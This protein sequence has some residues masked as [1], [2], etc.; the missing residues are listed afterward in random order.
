MDLSDQGSRIGRLAR[1]FNTQMSPLWPKR[2]RS[3][4]LS[5]TVHG[6][7]QSQDELHR[8]FRLGQCTE[9]THVQLLENDY[10]MTIFDYIDQASSSGMDTPS[11]TPLTG[12]R[13]FTELVTTE[14]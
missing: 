10:D 1:L 2:M 3:Q 13:A 5:Q 9:V 4:A 12:F 7:F 6:H 11:N 8:G 14:R